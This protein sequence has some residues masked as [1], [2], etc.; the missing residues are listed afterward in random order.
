MNSDS[1]DFPIK[2]FG[3]YAHEFLSSIHLELI[4]KQ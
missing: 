3:G 4:S 2:V 1:T